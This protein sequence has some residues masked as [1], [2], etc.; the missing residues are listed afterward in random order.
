MG[1]EDLTQDE[2]RA[3]LDKLFADLVPPSGAFTVYDV[4]TWYNLKRE[5][6]RNWVY[7][8][9]EAGNMREWGKH[10]GKKHYVLVGEK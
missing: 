5:K 9:I 10:E 7:A 4:A 3:E 2:V 8:Q 6:A 1:I